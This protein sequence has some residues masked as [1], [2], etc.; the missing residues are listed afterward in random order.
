MPFARRFAWQTGA[1]FGEVDYPFIQIHIKRDDSVYKH[2][3][4]AQ[5][6]CSA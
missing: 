1:Q 2:S 3:V 5:V 4:S 6:D